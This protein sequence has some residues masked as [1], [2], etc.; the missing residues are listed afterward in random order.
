MN[1]GQ[2]LP[3]SIPGAPGGDGRASAPLLSTCTVSAGLAVAQR[4]RQSVSDH[5]L[6]GSEDLPK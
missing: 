4:T 2:F 3:R 1:A 6:G 5:V